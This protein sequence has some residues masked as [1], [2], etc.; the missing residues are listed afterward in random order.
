MSTKGTDLQTCVHDLGSSHDPGPPAGMNCLEQPGMNSQPSKRMLPSGS[1]M[2]PDPKALPDMPPNPSL[3]PENGL[4]HVGQA[5][6]S[7]PAPHVPAPGVSQLCAGST[8]M[9]PP[10]LSYLRFESFDTFRRYSDPPFPIQ[11]KAQE[12]AF[13]NPPR[14][15]LGGIHLQSQMLLDPALYRIQR[16]LRRRLTAYVDVAVIGIAA[17]TVPLRSSSLSSASR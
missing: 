12:L 8:L 13:P 5:E 7:P 2:P 1:V 14:P 6:V 4:L 3:Q 10:H 9:P 17:E 15:A 11:S 16:P